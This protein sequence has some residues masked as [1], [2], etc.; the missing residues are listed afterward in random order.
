[1]RLVD[2]PTLERGEGLHA[3]IDAELAQRLAHLFQRRV[4]LLAIELVGLGQQHV[5]RQADVVGPLEHL[6]V[7]V[8]ERVTRVHHQHQAFQALA[9]FQ[10]VGERALPGVFDA[11]GDCRVA[12]AG[13]VDQATIIVDTEKVQ[14]L[15]AAGGAAGARQGFLIAQGVDRAGLAGVRAPGK[16]HFKAF[17]GR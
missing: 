12:V 5:H 2:A 16:G 9:L 17:V 11:L 13:Q 8:L 6:D 7:V 14:Q 3:E 4:G 1:M 10:V 15:G